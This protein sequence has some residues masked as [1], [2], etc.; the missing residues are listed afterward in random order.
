VKF[1]YME[2]RVHGRIDIERLNALGD[3]GWELC[4]VTPAESSLL[5][6]YK[7]HKPVHV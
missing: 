1:E 3:Q 7:R 5:L 2:E 6:L 4:A